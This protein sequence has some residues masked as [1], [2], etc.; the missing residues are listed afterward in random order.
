MP[1]PS[2]R[3]HPVPKNTFQRI[4]RVFHIK[5]NINYIFSLPV[6]C[7]AFSLQLAI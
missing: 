1:I 5:K 4:K 3:K 6:I 7:I 2:D